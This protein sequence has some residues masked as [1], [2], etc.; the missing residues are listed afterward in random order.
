MPTGV[1]TRTEKMMKKVKKNLAKG[2]SPSARKKATAK[3]KEYAKDPEW[4]K[5]VSENTKKGMK[6]PEARKKHLHGLEKARKKHG[7]NFKGGN[8]MHPTPIIALGIKLF[9]QCGFIW[10]LPI[11]TK[12]VKDIF[13]HIPSAYKVDFGNKDQK[14]AIEMD[15]ASHIPLKQRKKDR[16]KT[17]VLEAL[18]W[19]VIRLRHKGC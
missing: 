16:K 6:R 2:H 7:I 10:E 12:P 13:K 3:L 9:T 14:L 11:K 17:K 1:Y 18:G 19:T 4:I 8:G 15:G 5:L